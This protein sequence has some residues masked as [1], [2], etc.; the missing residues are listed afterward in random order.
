MKDPICDR[1]QQEKEQAKQLQQSVR[2]S[3]TLR[4]ACHAQCLLSH[5][6]SNTGASIFQTSYNPTNVRTGLKYLRKN[7]L[8]PAMVQYY[9][10]LAP[11]ISTLNKLVPG[12]DAV[13]VLEEQR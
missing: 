4:T 1:V 9:P 13:D 8:G 7:L 10:P 6:M 3:Q 11:K 2:R 5:A 12:F